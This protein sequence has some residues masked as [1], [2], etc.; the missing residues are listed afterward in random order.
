MVNDVKVMVCTNDPAASAAVLSLGAKCSCPGRGSDRLISELMTQTPDAV[1]ADTDYLGAGE[2]DG[3]RAVLDSCSV[4]PVLIVWGEHSGMFRNYFRSYVYDE[5]PKASDMEY[6][7]GAAAE[8]PL[9]DSAERSITEIMSGLGISAK[10]KGFRYLRCAVMLALHDNTVLDSVTKR[11]YPAV[12]KSHSTTATS[13]ERAIR[14][15]ISSAWSRA[16]GDTAFVESRLKWRVNYK[17]SYPTNSELIA[18][19]TDSLRLYGVGKTDSC[20]HR[21]YV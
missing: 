12:A 9:N 15:A 20:P 7:L 13:V 18:L 21:L 11:L 14:H 16:D 17:N 4:Q 1:L 8:S 6:A 3:L 5:V 19:I 2:I 10:V